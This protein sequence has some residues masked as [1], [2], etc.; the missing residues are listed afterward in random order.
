MNDRSATLTSSNDGWSDEEDDTVRSLMA[1]TS[2][3]GGGGC[4]PTDMSSTFGL[5]HSIAGVLG[6]SLPVSGDYSAYNNIGEFCH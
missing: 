6:P 2:K 1:A 4:S 3:K 5:G